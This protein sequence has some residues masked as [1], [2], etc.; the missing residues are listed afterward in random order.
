[1]SK[2]R[3]TRGGFTLIEVMLV[4]GILL[5]LGTVSVV[6][7]SRMQAAANKKTTKLLV[8]N[9]A[10]A[11]DLFY[12]VMNKYPGNETGLTA[13]ISVPDDEAEAMAW[14]EGGGPFLAD[15]K[16]PADP[17]RNELRY[18]LQEITSDM[19]GRAFVVWSLGP[20]GQDGTDDDIRSWQQTTR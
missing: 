8:D 11:V 6:G 9:T 19:M 3:R 15:G 17:W 18:E 14:N 13:M 12:T 4:I 1:M 16:V 7:L 20:D 10:D 5:V 2:S